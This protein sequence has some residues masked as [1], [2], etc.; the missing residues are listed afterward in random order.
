MNG[1]WVISFLYIDDD[2]PKLGKKEFILEF[3][4]KHDNYEIILEYLLEPYKHK[5]SQSYSEFMKIR[6]I[7]RNFAR[8]LLSHK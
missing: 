8:E 4:K 7:N 2:V 3:F 6:M 5:V 1:S